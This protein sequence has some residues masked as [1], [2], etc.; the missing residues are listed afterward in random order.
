MNAFKLDTVGPKPFN[1]LDHIVQTLLAS[2]AQ[3]SGRET[4]LVDLATVHPVIN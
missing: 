4:L 1:L 3:K 2:P